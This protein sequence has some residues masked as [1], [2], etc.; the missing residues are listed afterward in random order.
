MSVAE[1]QS[2]GAE[3]SGKASQEFASFAWSRILRAGT[4]KCFAAA[5]AAANSV[6]D[7]QLHVLPVQRAM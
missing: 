4:W 2:A 5:P 7:V 6:E 1:G 3:D